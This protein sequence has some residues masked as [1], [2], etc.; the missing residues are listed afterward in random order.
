MVWYYLAVALILSAVIWLVSIVALDY[1][2]YLDLQ[3]RLRKER[4][5]A[6]QTH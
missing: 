5:R 4:R 1:S 2:T 3:R 6:A